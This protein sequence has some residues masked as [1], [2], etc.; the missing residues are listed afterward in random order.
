MKKWKALKIKKDESDGRKKIIQK[1][2]I[3]SKN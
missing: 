2:S 3:P 1:G